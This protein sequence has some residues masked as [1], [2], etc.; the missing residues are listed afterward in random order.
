MAAEAW[1]SAVFGI[2]TPEGRKPIFGS[3]WR[4]WGVYKRRSEA[5]WIVVH[6]P[7]GCRLTQFHGLAIARRF[8][9]RIDGL[10]DWKAIDPTAE[11]DGGL[12]LQVHRAALAV[13][14]AQPQLAIVA[15]TEAS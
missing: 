9:E 15:G 7:T 1:E 10:T 4:S 8:C 11:A 12:F 6:L 5:S 2:T 13:T 3:V 14:G